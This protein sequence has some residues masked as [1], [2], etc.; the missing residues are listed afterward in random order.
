M[1]ERK[2]NGWKRRKKKNER[3]KDRRETPRGWMKKGINIKRTSSRKHQSSDEV[4][5]KSR[6]S[7]KLKSK[8][9][10]NQERQESQKSRKSKVERV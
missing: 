6:E 5:V 3:K 8:I 9:K 10:K 4:Y 1:N 7:Q 2:V